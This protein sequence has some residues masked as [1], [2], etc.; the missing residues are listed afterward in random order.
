[1]KYMSLKGAGVLMKVMD[2]SE[3]LLDHK[4]QGCVRINSLPGCHYGGEMLPSQ[5]V[6]LQ[7]RRWHVLYFL[8]LYL[9]SGQS[10]LLP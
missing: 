9:V 6:G 4:V 5:R 1:M 3:S 10:H 2:D 7:L 8:P